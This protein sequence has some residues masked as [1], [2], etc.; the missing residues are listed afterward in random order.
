MLYAHWAPCNSCGSESQ[1]LCA[2][3]HCMPGDNPPRC[4]AA[5]RHMS[6]CQ[7]ALPEVQTTEPCCCCCCCCWFHRHA[8]L[9]RNQHCKVGL[10]CS[11]TLVDL[12]VSAVA[13]YGGVGGMVCWPA[14]CVQICCRRRVC[15]VDLP[16]C[17]F[18]WLGYNHFHE[19]RSFHRRPWPFLEP[20]VLR[21][22]LQVLSCL[23][24]TPADGVLCC[25]CHCR[26]A[27]DAMSGSSSGS[28]IR[29]SCLE[30][31]ACS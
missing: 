27:A 15:A 4:T 17:V 28:N 9:G 18:T 1:Q 8:H 25:A 16:T 26:V 23:V 19:Q 30:P 6:T 7:C 13:P 10:V 5:L 22:L 3:P 14:W 11:I 31:G 29:S 21:S 24:A 2:V 20:G 12:H